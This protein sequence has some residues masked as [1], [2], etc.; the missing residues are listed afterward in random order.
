VQAHTHAPNLF[1]FSP[2]IALPVPARPPRPPA[3]RLLTRNVGSTASLL[4][5]V[6]CVAPNV[7]TFPLFRPA[8]CAELVRLSRE[9][10]EWTAQQGSAVLRPNSMNRYGGNAT[11]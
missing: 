5:Q 2:C 10:E 9:I 7:Y 8:F 6:S 4:S 11:T 3:R 1:D